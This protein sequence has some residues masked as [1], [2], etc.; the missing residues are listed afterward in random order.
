M[1]LPNPQ[2]R[3]I[4]LSPFV[5]PQVEQTLDPAL[6]L[7]FPSSHTGQAPEG[8]VVPYLPTAQSVHE[9]DAS[10]A[11]HPG[12]QVAHVLC[13]LAPTAELA[14]PASHAT[15][16]VEDGVELYFPTPQSVQV[17]VLT[18]LLNFPAGQAW[19]SWLNL[20]LMPMSPS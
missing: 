1:P 6:E 15:Q 8:G 17:L 12:L 19:H 4:V 3:H 20:H 10:A 11:Y 9:A 13:E 18:V 7:A 2:E 14:F 5:E 16:A